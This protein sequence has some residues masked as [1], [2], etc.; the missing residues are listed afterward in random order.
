VTVLTGSGG[1]YMGDSGAFG[2]RML[3]E[4]LANAP[5][6]FR[7]KLRTALS[8][9]G[10]AVRAAAASNAS[11]S[12]RIPDSLSVRTRFAGSRPGVY[13]VASR[14]KAPHARP[15]EGITGNAEFRH[16]FFGNRDYWFP[17]DTRPF[18]APA[19]QSEG[20]GAMANVKS[21]LD[22]ALR[23]VGLT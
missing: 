1:R 3:A 10:S 16:P 5:K 17:Q 23:Q 20:D 19:V 21:A 2:V 4:A 12:S 13:V 7:P 9:A 11:W 6:E 14:S 22:D 18:L 8:G 15:L